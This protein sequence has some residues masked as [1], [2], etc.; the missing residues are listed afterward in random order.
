MGYRLLTILAT[1]TLALTALGVTACSRSHEANAAGDVVS[2]NRD[3]ADAIGRSSDLRDAEAAID[4]GH[5]WRATQLLARVL[6]DPETRTPAALIVA[7]RASAGWGGWAQ[8]D[9]L[10]A[11]EPWIDARFGGE[12]RELLARSALERGADTLA[13]T[14]A[15][16]ALR[17]ASDSTARGAR[18]VY[19]AR[20]LERNNYFD[21]A[22]VVYGRAADA[23]RPVRDWLL[24]REA[25]SEQDSAARSRAFAR[26]S[27]AA[28]RPR[29]PWTD[30]Q[31]RERFA[32]EL[33]AAAR[34]AALGAAVPALRLR[35]SVAPDSATRKV[36]KV[37][38][39][40]FIRSHAGSSDA[41]AAVDV[42]DKGFTNPTPGE[43]LIVAR[44]SATS[45]PVPRAITAFEHALAEPAL[46]TAAD[47]LQYGQVLA[48]AN[49]TRDAAAQFAMVRGPLAAQ[50]AYQRARLTLTSDPDV[51]RAALRDVVARYPGDTAVVGNALYLLADL[52][53]DTGN[54]DDAR[55]L[56]QELATSYPTSAR[57]AEAGFRAALI[58]YV[59]G[60]AR[61]AAQEFDSL[62]ARL[63]R[64]DEATAAR[65]WSGRAWAVSGNE[66]VARARWQEIVAQQPSSY[67]AWVSAKRLSVPMPMPLERADSFPRS[68]SVDAAFA[69]IAE[70]ER[71]GM[72]VE[73]RFESDALEEEA[74][75]STDRLLATAHGFL[76]NG[77]AW[78]AVWLAQ[79]LVDAGQRDTRTYRL[80]FPVL[81][82]DE[83][84][85][86]AKAHDLDPALVAGIIRQE[87]SY[88][89]HA[90]SVAGARGLMQV[91]PSVGADVARS[92]DFPT[93]SPA[94]LFD[95]DANLQIGTAHL[96]TS[97]RQYG[98]LPRVLAAYN[99][100][101][102]R[103]DR[104]ATKAGSEDPEVFAE[105]IPFA[106]TRDYVR[107]VQRN[108][109]VYRALY[110]W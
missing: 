53:T 107:L 70:L 106:E 57:A 5:P 71:L 32:D 14:Q 103:V 35:L 94:L 47:R 59:H 88:N 100:G 76:V 86:N 2:T 46:L 99:A 44:S 75:T 74:K 39:L 33:G 17:D 30:A 85:R 98:A 69:R 13:L 8:V 60:S 78:R 105:R 3:L 48:R 23:L 10:L 77:Q 65:Y 15:R 55:A 108:V 56:F 52:T 68:S 40:G 101:G 104:W 110:G 83:L 9:S 96:V 63:P 54:D 24:L 28:A 87:S 97:V 31:A 61:A 42:L 72:D 27:L 16:A 1:S 21:S 7:A 93:W 90:V 34:Y 38:L 43:E 11:R 12:G 58:A 102:S 109:A 80:L 67:Y 81:D 29:I 4:R 51:T 82:D 18:L 45:G 92:L 20:A 37:E 36:I 89:T 79:K 84:T 25:G 19:F 26:V 22:A 66:A 62:D 49:R 50:A 73:A 6:R 41:K 95:P 91:M 64:S